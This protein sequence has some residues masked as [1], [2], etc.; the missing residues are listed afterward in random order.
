MPDFHYWNET[1]CE[2]RFPI[3]RE[4]GE[5]WELR[6]TIIRVRRHGLHQRI[7]T[8][9]VESFGLSISYTLQ[10]IRSDT[11]LPW[12]FWGT[13]KL[14]A[15]LYSITN[16]YF[17]I[18]PRFAHVSNLQTLLKFR[19]GIREQLLEHWN[20]TPQIERRWGTY[21]NKDRWLYIPLSS[22]QFS[23]KRSFEFG[24]WL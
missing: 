13:L 15:I 22:V 20:S 1:D 23:S 12:L 24:C 18:F 8:F 16:V 17:S 6:I 3:N 4:D 9:E 5:L 11:L 19:Q 14:S 2:R 10:C 21:Y 7:Q